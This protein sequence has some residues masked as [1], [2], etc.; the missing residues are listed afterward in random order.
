MH[1]YDIFINLRQ[2]VY[3]CR[4]HHY[5]Y[6]SDLYSTNTLDKVKCG[7]TKDT[8]LDDVSRCS[9]TSVP[10]GMTRHC[11]TFHKNENGIETLGLYESIV[12]LHQHTKTVIIH[13]SMPL[14][15]MNS[16]VKKFMLLEALDN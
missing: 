16:S 7:T 9:I 12:N 5:Y 1:T 3:T 4:T 11:P 6:T 14:Y 2:L 10:F 13:I 15:Q 8:S